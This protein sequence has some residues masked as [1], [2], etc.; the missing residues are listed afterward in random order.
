MININANVINVNI[1]KH[2][3]TNATKMINHRDIQSQ[4]NASQS[5][6]T[7][8]CFTTILLHYYCYCIN[9]NINI[10]NNNNT[11]YYQHT[12]WYYHNHITQKLCPTGKYW[13]FILMISTNSYLTLTLTVI[14]TCCGIKINIIHKARS[15]LH[16]YFNPL[17]F[18]Y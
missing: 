2:H 18:W 13:H 11:G 15:I 7:K 3:K 12:L 6:N 17:V 5:T 9:I 4:N 8:N 16:G 1:T 14:I 10:I